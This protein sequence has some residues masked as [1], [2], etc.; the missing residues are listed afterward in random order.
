VTL[1]SSFLKP[2]QGYDKERTSNPR[3]IIHSTSTQ[4][5]LSMKIKVKNDKKVFLQMQMKNDFPIIK[6][7]RTC[8]QSKTLNPIKDF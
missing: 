3:K 8:N 4:I 1:N 2:D 5:K 6:Q 7:S